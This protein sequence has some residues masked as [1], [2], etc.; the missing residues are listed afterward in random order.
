[1]KILEKLRRK[2]ISNNDIYDLVKKMNETML[3]QGVKIVALDS[4]VK[5][6]RC[7]KIKD[8]EDQVVDIKARKM[9][10]YEK[11]IDNLKIQ[12]E[13]KDTVI[14][15]QQEAIE[16]ISKQKDKSEADLKEAKQQVKKLEKLV[17]KYKEDGIVLPKRVRGTTAPKQAVK[18]TV[19]PV[20]N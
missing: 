2:E 6:F 16:K 15:Q 12:I 10:A 18:E 1:M 20:K 4:N 7:Q 19:R 9:N 17:E 11:Q 13:S 8:L 14:A 3:E 5:E